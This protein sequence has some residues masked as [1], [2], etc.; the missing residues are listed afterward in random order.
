MWAPLWL[1]GVEVVV[2]FLK[3]YSRAR[4]PW[5]FRP[6]GNRPQAGGREGFLRPTR[7]GE[8]TEMRH[9]SLRKLLAASC[10]VPIY[11]SAK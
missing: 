1:V 7:P 10:I 9:S 6:S 3:A 8:L 5:M 4:F 2:R 11:N